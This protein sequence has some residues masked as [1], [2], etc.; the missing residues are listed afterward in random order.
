MEKKSRVSAEMQPKI[1]DIAHAAAII[2]EQETGIQYSAICSQSAQAKLHKARL[3]FVGILYSYGVP[4]GKIAQITYKK[5]DV[6]ERLVAEFDENLKKSADY[7]QLM[8]KADK[9][10][11]TK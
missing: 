8:T 6:I 2:V 1:F 7:R 5:K 9:L 4:S 10:L 11:T 3:L